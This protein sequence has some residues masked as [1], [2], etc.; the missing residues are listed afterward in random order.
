MSKF[1]NYLRNDK[2]GAVEYVLLIAGVGG[3]IIAGL[4]VQAV[5]TAFNAMFTGVFNQAKNAATIP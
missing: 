5:K 3:L 4:Q 1:L 2:G